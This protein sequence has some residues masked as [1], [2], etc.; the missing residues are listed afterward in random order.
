[1]KTVDVTF[2]KTLE[3]EYQKVLAIQIAK[4]NKKK[5]IEKVE[6]LTVGDFIKEPIL[7]ST[8]GYIDKG[9]GDVLLKITNPEYIIGALFT[10][11]DG[12]Q[13][14]D[15]YSAWGTEGKIGFFPSRSTG[16]RYIK[17]VLVHWTGDIYFK[18]Y[19]KDLV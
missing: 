10:F 16:K 5:K 19:I 8:T 12:T 4:R 7:F 14:F 6:S 1:M 11:E 3:F 18:K 15:F 13:K 9:T 17:G 2:D